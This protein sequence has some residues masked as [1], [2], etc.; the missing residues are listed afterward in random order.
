MSR[1]RRTQKRRSTARRGVLT[2]EWILM[3]TLLVVGLIGA[4]G[5]VRNAM[6]DELMDLEGAI[7]AMNFSGKGGPTPAPGDSS[8]VVVDDSYAWWSTQARSR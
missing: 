2:F 4:L 7:E 8:A 1:S 3:V 6:L 5:A